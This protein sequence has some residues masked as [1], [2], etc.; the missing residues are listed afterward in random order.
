MDLKEVLA[1]YQRLPE[2]EDRPLTDVNQS[3][4]VRMHRFMWRR[5][6][7]RLRT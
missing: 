4:S 5:D 1:K 7:E 6:R 3:Q 2:F